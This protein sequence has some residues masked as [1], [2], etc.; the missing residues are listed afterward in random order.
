MAVR[1]AERYWSAVSALAERKKNFNQRL[2]DA[3]VAK[4]TKVKTRTRTDCVCWCLTARDPEIS[5][6]KRSF[7]RVEQSRSRVGRFWFREEEK[8]TTFPRRGA[9]SGLFCLSSSQ[10]AEMLPL[11]PLTVCFGD[12]NVIKTE[13]LELNRTEGKRPALACSFLRGWGN[14]H[15]ERVSLPHLHHP[16]PPKLTSAVVRGFC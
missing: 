6:K 2:A 4:D 8:F 12:F 7:R 11:F 16:L 13:C 5:R 14:A 9:G 15:E 3:A 1:P 10:T